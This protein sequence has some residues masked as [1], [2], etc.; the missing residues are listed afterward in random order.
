MTEKKENRISIHCILA[1]IYFLA[2]PLTI[3]TNEYGAS[4][5]KIMTVPI[6]GYFI[7]SFMFYK[8]EFEINIVHLLLVLY[9]ISTLLTLFIDRSANSIDCVVGYFLNAAI[10]ICL[11]IVSYNE[12]ELKLLE[13]TQIVLLVLLTGWVLYNHT[14]VFN[15]T[16]LSIMGQVADPNFFVGYFIFPLT[17]TM[18]KIVESKYR[19]LYMLLAGTSLY[20]VFQS[21]SR[22]GF[23]AV[24]VT[25]IAFALIYPEKA[26]SKLLILVG[27][28]AFFALLWAILSP[29][30]SEEVIER[31]TVDAVVDSNG[32]H[33]FDIW[34][35]AL[36]TLKNSSWELIIGRGIDA[37]HMMLV[38]GRE[39]PAAIH[40]HFIQIIYNQGVFGFLMFFGLTGAAFLRCIKKRKTVSIAIVGM[41]ALA[42]SLSFNQTTR[43]FWNLIA[44][45]ALVYPITERKKECAEERKNEEVEN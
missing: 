22:G 32:T 8:K 13:N 44:Y 5:L 29:M 31:M 6:G 35:S 24:L 12:R 36:E 39:Q 34:K 45:A 10:Y 28:V 20:V 30:L 4:L 2:L 21:G 37:T 41:L 43:T 14:M 15:R 19:I 16:T 25:V 33:R 7:I 27:G 9:T 38:G 3:W 23:M 42:V 26:K 17:V 18:K 1:C 40:N 11:T